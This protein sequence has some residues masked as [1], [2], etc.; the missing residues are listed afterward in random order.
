[1]ALATSF[2]PWAKDMVQAVNTCAGSGNVGLVGIFTLLGDLRATNHCPPPAQSS[3]GQ[4]ALTWM[5][6]NTVSARQ[7]NTSALAQMSS[8][9]WLCFSLSTSSTQ[10]MS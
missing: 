4:P 7:S 3:A 8:A 10:C 1:M 5:Y 9:I 6:L 2:A